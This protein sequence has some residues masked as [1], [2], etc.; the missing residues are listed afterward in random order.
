MESV[1][2]QLDNF[3]ALLFDSLEFQMA[4]HT[5][6]NYW[7]ELDHIDTESQDGIET[8]VDYGFDQMFERYR[9]S[10]PVLDI[11]EPWC[12]NLQDILWIAMD[13]PYPRDINQHIDRVLENCRRMFYDQIWHRLNTA[14]IQEVS[15]AQIIQR[16]WKKAVSD[17]NYVVCRKRL[18]REHE[19][20]IR[21]N[22]PV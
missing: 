5:N 19:D 6:R 14:M 21:E 2:E 15:G 1:E 11:L 8:C 20:L 12:E 18:M 3:E 4:I 16:A 10:R 22:A 17:P 13:V 9:Y 7:E